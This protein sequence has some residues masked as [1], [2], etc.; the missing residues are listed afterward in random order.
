MTALSKLLTARQTISRHSRTW[1]CTFRADGDE[2]EDADAH[3]TAGLNDW[4]N[5]MKY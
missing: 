5:K 2:D 3:P 4:L 1:R